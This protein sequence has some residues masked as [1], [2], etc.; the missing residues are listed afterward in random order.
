MMDKALKLIP[1]STR[2]PSSLTT[3]ATLLNLTGHVIRMDDYYSAHGGSADVWEGIWLKDTGKCKVSHDFIW[4]FLYVPKQTSCKVAVKVVRTN[5]ENENHNEK[6]N[7][8]EGSLEILP[9]GCS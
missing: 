5:N 4:F 2:W 1:F 8:V 6:M 9:Q 7:K 3:P